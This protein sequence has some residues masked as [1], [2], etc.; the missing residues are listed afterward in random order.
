MKKIIFFLKILYRK[1]I[2]IFVRS[3][4]RKLFKKIVY[5]YRYYYL[6]FSLISKKNV[7]IILGA[8]LTSDK[9][10]FSTNEQWL[11]ITNLMHWKRIFRGKT[12]IYCAMAEHVFEH[13]TQKEMR[14]AL[15]QIY[16]H[17]IPEGNLRIAVPDGNHPNPEYRKHTGI[18]GI[19]AD[20]SDHK[21]FIKFEFLKDEL[22]KIG[23]SVTLLEGYDVSGNLNVN[24]INKDLGNIMRSRSNFKYNS[25]SKNYGWDFPDSNTS[26][27]V[28]AKKTT[29]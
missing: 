7:K 20:A 11:D 15:Q 4:N 3:F 10:W 26:L 17:L 23:F 18:N 25:N 1:L 21:Q 12:K 2:P 13:L 27:I 8:A 29:A 6:R 14:I 16:N 5:L 24:K 9:G 28:D 19:G 22:E